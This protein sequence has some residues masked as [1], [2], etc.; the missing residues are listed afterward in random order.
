MN[1]DN[2]LK[3]GAVLFQTGVIAFILSCI[4]QILDHS[5]LFRIESVTLGNLYGWL[6]NWMPMLS[7]I[8]A[9]VGL[10]FLIHA[11]FW[12]PGRDS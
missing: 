2:E 10:C 9:A 6:L 1:H 11:F 4:Y 5:Y 12:N 8:L 7:L 3:V